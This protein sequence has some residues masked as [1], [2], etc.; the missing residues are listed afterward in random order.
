MKVSLIGFM[1]SGKST[2]AACLSQYL[3]LR[4]YE[5]DQMILNESGRDTIPQIFELDGEIAFREL[6]I[7]AA[8]K[9]SHI[10]A[11]VVSCGGGI[12]QNKICIDYLR[13]TRGKIVYLHAD[14]PLI[15]ERIMSDGTHSR[16]MFQ[17]TPQAHALYTLREPLYRAY[18]DVT[19]DTRDLKPEDIARQIASRVL[20]ISD[21]TL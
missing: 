2:I 8:R 1:G 12:V 5:M 9:L 14:F 13:Q 19:V 18:A 15:T 4:C 3:S 21:L 11:G 7:S 17:N 6:E 16:P 10:A 20:P